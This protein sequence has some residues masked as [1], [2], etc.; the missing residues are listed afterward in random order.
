MLGMR[1][2]GDVIGAVAMS[3]RFGG[4]GRRKNLARRRRVGCAGRFD[5]LAARAMTGWRRLCAGQMV[6][7]MRCLPT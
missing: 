6:V 3:R 5:W 4:E 7:W 1:D 2:D